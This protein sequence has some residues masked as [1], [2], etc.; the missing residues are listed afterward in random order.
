MKL[1]SDLKLIRTIG[2]GSLT[3]PTAIKV[4]QNGNIFVID[5]GKLKVFRVK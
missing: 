4:M 1:D 5:S 2:E 3:H